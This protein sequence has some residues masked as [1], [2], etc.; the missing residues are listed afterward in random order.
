M[1]SFKQYVPNKPSKFANKLYVLAD[2]KTFYLVSFK[3]YTGS[4]T[5]APGLPDP[6][7]A[8]LHLVPSVSETSRNITSENYYTS[9]PL[10]MELKSRDLTLVGTMK[11]NKA[12]WQQQ[13]KEQFN[14]HLTMQTI[15][16]CCTLLQGK[17]RGSS[18]C[19]LCIPK[20]E[21]GG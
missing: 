3:I 7:Q 5:L 11:K 13:M 19:Q 1:C 20:K 9:V 21:R 10:T 4:G 8:V 18:S 6:T 14:M 12:F 2:S 15:S 16:L 17:T